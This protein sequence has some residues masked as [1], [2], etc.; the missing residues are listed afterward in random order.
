MDR[1]LATPPVEPLPAASTR[2]SERLSD[3]V[4][5][6]AA[7]GSRSYGSNA[8]YRTGELVQALGPNALCLILIVFGSLAMLPVPGIH[9]V[10]APILAIAAGELALGRQSLWLPR[11]LADRA[12]PR[13]A[14]ERLS[15]RGDRLLRA[16]ERAVHPRLAWVTSR[17][18]RRC[19]GSLGLAVAFLLLFPVPF[20]NIPLG[21]SILLMGLGIVERD[22]V[23]ALAGAALGA[24][25]LA[26]EIGSVVLAASRLI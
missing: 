11:F 25:C 6:L 17:L 10:C 12:V 16:V 24:I 23:F 7:A 1:H 4:A 15:A 5:R 8:P 2:A 26:I 18:G 14:A 19:L 3:L 9:S 20:A 21:L 22:G 13:G